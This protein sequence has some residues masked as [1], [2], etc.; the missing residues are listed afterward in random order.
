M[1]RIFFTSW[2]NSQKTINKV[3]MRIWMLGFSPVMRR[4]LRY[5]KLQCFMHDSQETKPELEWKEKRKNPQKKKEWENER[6]P[7][8]LEKSTQQASQTDRVSGPLPSR[9]VFRKDPWKGSG[10]DSLCSPSLSLSPP[11]LLSA[12]FSLHISHTALLLARGKRANNTW[13]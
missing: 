8:S 6:N 9:A 13:L 3:R 5:F 11:T 10:L 1:L 2:T 7:T 4:S 12:S